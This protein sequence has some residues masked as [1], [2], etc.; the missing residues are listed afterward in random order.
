[1]PTGDNELAIQ[2]EYGPLDYLTSVASQTRPR[3]IVKTK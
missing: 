1:V 2:P 3:R